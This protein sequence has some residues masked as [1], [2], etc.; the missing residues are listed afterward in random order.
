MSAEHYDKRGED[1]EQKQSSRI[2]G[3]YKLYYKQLVTY[4]YRFKIIDSI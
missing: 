2:E 4:A 1:L 3:L